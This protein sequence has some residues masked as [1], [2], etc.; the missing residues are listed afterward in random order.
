VSD[1]LSEA[2]YVNLCEGCDSLLLAEDS[3]LERVAIPWLHIIREHPMFLKKYVDLFNANSSD[4][5]SESGVEKARFFFNSLANFRKYF[6]TKGSFYRS[7]IDGVHKLD[8][9][10][11]SHLL[12]NRDAGKENDSY[13]GDLPHQLNKLG[14]KVG[15]ILINHS[16]LKAQE[17]VDK[18]RN[19]EIPR[20]IFSPILPFKSEA[21]MLSR[22]RKES[23]KLKVKASVLDEG[24]LKE[25]T[26]NASNQATT[27]LTQTT[28]RLGPQI[29]ELIADFKPGTIVT[30]FEGHAWE[31]I[32]YSSAR[33]VNSKTQCVGY[34][35]ASI[36]KLQHAIRRNLKP[37]YNPD[38]I[39][40]AGLVGK[41][42]LKSSESYKLMEIE[43]LGSD[44]GFVNKNQV[45]P[46]NLPDISKES[47][48]V[49]PEGDLD[50]CKILFEYSIKC[51]F[52]CPNIRFIWRLHP[53]L[54]F[55]KIFKKYPHLSKYPENI[56]VSNSSLN[57]DIEQ[58]C[59]VLYRGTTAVIQSI[60]GG[61]IPLY[62]NI[63]GEM[64]IDPLYDISNGKVIL[65]TQ[66]DF[67]YFIE[68]ISNFV[69]DNQHDRIDLLKY[70][71]AYYTNFDVNSLVQIVSREHN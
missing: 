27:S 45:H 36:F 16:D 14:F 31:R 48:L 66:A 9:L 3:T 60:K 40:T 39:L 58:S 15:I 34:Q 61:L 30:T 7:S 47:C 52:S 11:V 24:F 2:E 19:S 21:A 68:N 69:N 20:F 46:A 10:F 63:P 57:E 54:S 70:C 8:L 37:E 28:Y 26:K 65:K 44:R 51:A 23:K 29:A 5:T 42:Q 53:I 41:E 12:N 33:R 49:L 71:E 64:V 56:S 6:Q 22:L 67:K 1:Y 38:V 43:V 25:I 32:I 4:T 50:E 59:I 62:L 18:W 13:F 17:A 55:E 35:H